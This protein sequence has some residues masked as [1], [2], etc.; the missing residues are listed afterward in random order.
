MTA[1]GLHQPLEEPDRVSFPESLGVPLDT[2]PER[3]VRVF[4]RLDHPVGGHPHD[5]DPAPRFVDTLVVSAVDVDPRVPNERGESRVGRELHRMDGTIPGIASLVFERAGPQC[6]EVLNE[7]AAAHDGHE[8]R[9]VADP[10]DRPPNLL[11]PLEERALEPAPTLPGG[12]DSTPD[13][14][15]VPPGR[16]VERPPAE[17]ETGEPPFG[18][19]IRRGHAPRLAPGPTHGIGVGLFD[20]RPTRGVE[21]GRNADGGTHAT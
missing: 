12:V 6:R 17:Q 4:D 20:R 21:V 19:R 2:H 10:E 15:P 9:P 13:L 8:L 16:D 18:I 5:A 3:M 14:L 11:G 1:S 7:R